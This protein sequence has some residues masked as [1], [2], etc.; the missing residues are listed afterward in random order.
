MYVSSMF[1][2]LVLFLSSLYNQ[3]T[4]SLFVEELISTIQVTIHFVVAELV[5]HKCWLSLVIFLPS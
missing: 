1:E 5:F 4:D 3:G 2:S